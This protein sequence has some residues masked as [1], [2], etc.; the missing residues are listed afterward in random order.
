MNTHR[1]HR[2]RRAWL[3]RLSILLPVLAIALTF[4]Q[5]LKEAITPNS[6]VELKIH[7]SGE[8][9]PLECLAKVI[10]HQSVENTPFY[11]TALCFLDLSNRDRLQ[12][13]KYV[14]K[15]KK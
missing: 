15:A 1:S 10:R 13:E 9:A 8:G 12:L 7:L 4:A 5:E 3:A 2:A 6:I 11:E 14:E